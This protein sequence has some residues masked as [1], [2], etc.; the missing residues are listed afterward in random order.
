MATTSVRV[1]RRHR[2]SAREALALALLAG[3]L[4]V[5]ATGLFGPA[6]ALTALLLLA[7]A[8]VASLVV[9]RRHRGGDDGGGGVSTGR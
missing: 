3:L 7:A 1:G 9:E 8:T 5:A 6:R 4:L 2:H